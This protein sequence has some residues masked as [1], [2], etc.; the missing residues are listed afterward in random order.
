[1]SDIFSRA[2]D[3]EDSA[4][5]LL[6]DRTPS[7]VQIPSELEPPPNI[8]ADLNLAESQQN[9]AYLLPATRIRFVKKALLRVLRI[10]YRGQV[11][12]NS[13]VFRVLKAWD[14]R[15][16]KLLEEISSNERRLNELELKQSSEVLALSERIGLG[17]EDFVGLEETIGHYRV[18]LDSMSESLNELESSMSDSLKEVKS[19]M[20][21]SVNGI[22]NSYDE[23][24]KSLSNE[25]LAIE[26]KFQE[27]ENSLASMQQH[28]I[29]QQESFN[30]IERDLQHIQKFQ[31]EIDNERKPLNPAFYFEFEN[32]NRGK[33]EE[34]LER[35]K[36]YLPILKGC[37]EKFG[38]E[39]KFI[40]L[41]C[42][43]GELLEISYFSGIDMEG[44]DQNA[45]MISHCR[46]LGLKASEGDLM[47]KLSH[48]TDNTLA[49]VTAL[50]V[51][52]HLSYAQ[53]SSMLTL[54]REKL[55]PGGCVILE[56]INPL[57]VYAMRY[58]YMDPTHR[59]P[60]PDKTC[61]FLLKIHGFVN[62]ETL[63]LTP[64]QQDP[65]LESLDADGRLTPL[66][67][68]IFGYQDYAVIGMK[69]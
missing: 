43:R 19:S 3:L 32:L 12:F 44:F 59:Q 47:E 15:L 49:G 14:L 13:A 33:R 40:D 28:A 64:V 61:E 66:R 68:L 67:D 7:S 26:S 34:I 27:L 63:F 38:Q 6:D 17:E 39:A 37:A 29:K 54:T 57:S 41:G 36:V 46:S 53:I 1:M 21:D 8:Q 9:P 51:I 4:E 55:R 5:H 16:R 23:L 62:I 30:R 50:Q 69:P 20:C 11:E 65:A 18:K 2:A 45:I 58:F 42:G 31:Q 24:K 10:Y 52:E 48:F 25:V 56:T 22:K 35:Q 60:V